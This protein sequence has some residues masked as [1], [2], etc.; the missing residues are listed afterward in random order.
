MLPTTT[1]EMHL[2]LASHKQRLDAAAVGLLQPC[3]VQPDA[4]LQRV[5]Q[6]RVLRTDNGQAAVRRRV[7]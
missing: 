7:T 5:L 1:C 4:E 6:R 2:D 3:V